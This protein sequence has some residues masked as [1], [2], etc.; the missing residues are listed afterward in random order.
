ME[1]LA[2]A[3]EYMDA[4]FSGKNIANL[5]RLL[6]PDFSF[7]GPFYQF[8]SAQDYIA[9]LQ[10]DPPE[11]FAYDVIKSF[12]DGDSVGLFY[13]FTKEGITTPMAQ[14]FTLQD[15]KISAVLLIFDTG[16]AFP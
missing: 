3:L 2:L 1:P 4:V 10:A 8:H 11:G 16:V 14:L 7:H 5:S 9:A 13:Q 15:E 6:T 12:S